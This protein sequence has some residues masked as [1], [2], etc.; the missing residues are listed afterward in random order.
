MK[1]FSIQDKKASFFQ[2]PLTMR[3]AGEAIRALQTTINKGDNPISDYPED[4][5][6]VELGDFLPDDG[7]IVLHDSPKVLVNATELI[8]Q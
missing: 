5:A 1:L 7:S 4:F 3:N 2:N 8:E 6:L